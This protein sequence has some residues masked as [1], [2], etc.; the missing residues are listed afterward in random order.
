MKSL[1]QS[2]VVAVLSALACTGLHAQ[3]VDMKVTIPFAFQAGN[4]LM[5]AGDYL[6]HE[7]GPVVVVRAR[8]GAGR[9]TS[10]MTNSTFDPGQPGNGQLRFDRY[11]S[12]YFLTEI[13]NPSSHNGRQLPPAAREKQLARGGR[14]VQGA[15]VLASNN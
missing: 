8:D 13:R 15:V 12:E 7:Q 11:G 10:L 9:V 14:P 3:T 5:P 6:I 1:T 4:T 2:L